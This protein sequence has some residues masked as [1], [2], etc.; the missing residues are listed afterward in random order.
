MFHFYDPRLASV[1]QHSQ[2][3]SLARVEIYSCIAAVQQRHSLLTST[4][5]VQMN[6]Q[7]FVTCYETDCIVPN[8]ARCIEKKSKAQLCAIEL[9]RIQIHVFLIQ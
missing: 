9:D 4:D 2:R 6:G 1:S 3:T 5:F 7:V 8:L